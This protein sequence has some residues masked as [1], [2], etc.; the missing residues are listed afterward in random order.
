VAQS[1]KDV[2]READTAF[3]DRAHLM[4]C[5]QDVCDNFWP[6]VATFTRATN[7]QRYADELTTSV[8]CILRREF[9]NTIQHMLRPEGVPWFAM[10]TNSEDDMDV[11]T[12]QYLESNDAIMR[13]AM[14]DPR[15]KFARATKMV[16]AG[17]GTL[18]QWPMQ[19]TINSAGDGLL[20]RDW[21]LKDVAWREN[22]DRD[23]DKVWRRCS[24]P[25]AQ[26]VRMFPKVSPRLE[27]LAARDPNKQVRCLHVEMPAFEYEIKGN[28]FG[29]VSLYVDMDHEFVMEA[30]PLPEISYIIPRWVQCGDSPYAV[31]PVVVVALPDARLIQS[32]SLVILEAGEKS[33]NPPVLYREGALRGDLNLYAGGATSIDPEF[34]KDGDGLRYMNVDRVGFQHGMAMR[35]SVENTLRAAF[36]LDKLD[37]FPDRGNGDVTREEI[38]Q[39]VQQ[40]VRNASP[41]FSPMEAEYNGQL[42]VKTYNLL[43]RNGAFGPDDA[44]PAAIRGEDV[45]FVF[46]SPLTEAMEQGKSAVF[47][48]TRAMLAEVSAI[49]PSATAMIDFQVALRDSLIGAGTPAKWM[50]TDE[51]M[52]EIAQAQAEEQRSQTL[53]QQMG[54]GAEIAQKIGD[55][56]QSLA[57]LAPDAGA[58]V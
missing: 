33:T 54:Q 58:L 37:V 9:T 38:L 31:S 15:A 35:E 43:R 52:Q 19:V 36:F 44:V 24:F 50:R 11:A 28:K 55:A 30:V 47:A 46:R 7:M 42:C 25:A 6:E 45:D 39:R 8:P 48:Q 49:E 20:Y 1:V 22:A 18:G 3:A 53:M 26:L 40:Y 57:A 12:R 14:Y 13:R 41:L 10:R 29:Y 4:S 56:G 21:H 32:M 51:Q 5:W 2:V 16:D 17:F 27:A 34:D 23:L